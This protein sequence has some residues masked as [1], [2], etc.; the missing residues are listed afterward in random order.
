M[1]AK[2]V[3]PDPADKASRFDRLFNREKFTRR[4]LK[5]YRVAGPLV[6]GYFALSM[7]NS[8]GAFGSLTADDVPHWILVIYSLLTFGV[9][10]ATPVLFI[11]ASVGGLSVKSDWRFAL[12]LWLCSFAT[13][14][15]LVTIFMVR[16]LTLEDQAQVWTTAQ[17]LLL[18][19]AAWATVVGY[20]RKSA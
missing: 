5:V 10:L 2:P 20:R 9:A 11:I 7:L 19:S 1:K 15:F 18:V 4:T 6:L 13:G 12:P 16:Q 17:L 3:A 8:S 14:L